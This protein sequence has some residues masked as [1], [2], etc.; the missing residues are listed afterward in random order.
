M[1]T[2]III[3]ASAKS[4][5]LPRKPLLAETGKPL[6]IHTYEA[7]LQSKLAD[8]VLIAADE[9]CFHELV[10]KQ[11]CD[12]WIIGIPQECRNGTQRV[13]EAAKSLDD[14]FDIILNLQCDEPL[15]TGEM[16]D[17][18]ISYLKSP[19]AGLEDQSDDLRFP[20]AATLVA[21]LNP[22]AA[23]NTSIVKAAVEFPNKGEVDRRPFLCYFSRANLAGAMQHIGVYGF[24]KKML[25]LRISKMQETNLSRA[26]RLEQLAWLGDIG[27]VQVDHAPLSINTREDYDQFVAMMR[28]S[29]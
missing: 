17:K 18:L 26:E 20:W 11:K 28:Q 10:N 6:V 25:E 5:R 7:A 24:E 16:L 22:G 4:K 19:I 15:V 3:P 13:A 29:A 21:P 9:E 12:A 1:K 23:E 27:V 2:C 14:E 8:H